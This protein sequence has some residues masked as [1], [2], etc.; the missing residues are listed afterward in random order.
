MSATV[1]LEQAIRNGIN[2]G[3]C[4]VCGSGLVPSNRVSFA[5]CPEMAPNAFSFDCP[6]NLDH[7]EA[8]DLDV[9]YVNRA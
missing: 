2:P 9:Y 1:I 3:R 7:I 8:V 5:K 6:N 4:P